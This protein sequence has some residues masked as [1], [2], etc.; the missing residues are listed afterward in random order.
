MKEIYL[1]H[2]HNVIQDRF[3]PVPT[4]LVKRS[5]AYEGLVTMRETRREERIAREHNRSILLPGLRAARQ[6]SGR[7][8]HELAERAGVSKTTISALEAGRRGAYMRSVRR[9]ADALG[10]DVADLVE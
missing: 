2:K 7:T 8:Q 9:I 3:S 5:R 6:N 10:T 4:S 1:A